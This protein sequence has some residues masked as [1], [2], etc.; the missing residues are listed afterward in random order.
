M[1]TIFTIAA[2]VAAAPLVVAIYA[3][4]LYPAILWLVA[5]VRP[6]KATTSVEA[7]WPSVTITVPVYNAEASIRATLQRLLELDYPRDKLQ[8]LVISDASSDR[9]DEIAGQFR[10]RGVELLRLPQRRGKT[11]AEN[12]AVSVARGDIIVNADATVLLPRESLKALVR[13]F[14]DPTI[15]LSSGRDRSVGDEANAGTHTESGY[16]GYEMW[17]RDLE[18]KVGSIVGASGCFYGIRR[19]I[20]SEPLPPDLS[21]DFASALI[22]RQQ[23]Y[24]AVSVAA[25]VCLVP[26][27]AE[28]RTE[29]ERKVRTMTRGLRTLFHLREMMNPFRYGAFALM[30]ISHKFLRWLPFLLAPFAILALTVLATRFTPALI[31]LAAGALVT[32]FGVAGIRHRETRLPKA[33]AIA[34]FFVAACYAGL[35]AWRNALRH[36]QMATWEPTPRPE[37]QT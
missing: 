23:G 27:T 12:T 6:I 17:L 14:D 5:R 21:W 1:A 29:L 10:D 4:A 33:I 26:R 9:T 35:V 36:A 32:A 20:H 22:A 3:Y 18:T 28:L 2:T 30:L 19:S 34:A 37:L 31:L 8:V 16:V 15:G 25:A 13:V 7:A 24:R 11:T